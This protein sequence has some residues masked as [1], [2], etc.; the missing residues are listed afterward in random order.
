VPTAAVPVESNR[1]HTLHGQC[2]GRVGQRLDHAI[3]DSSLLRGKVS[4]RWTARS[5]AAR[6]GTAARS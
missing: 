5:P 6:R 4:N 1:P 2:T 3:L